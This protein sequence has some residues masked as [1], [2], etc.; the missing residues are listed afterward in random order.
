MDI[1]VEITIDYALTDIV[2]GR[3]D[4]GVRSGS[5]VAKDMREGHGRLRKR[6]QRRPSDD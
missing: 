6:A 4:A 3:F 5:Q 2:A 1:H